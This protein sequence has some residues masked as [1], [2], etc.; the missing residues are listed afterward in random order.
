METAVCRKGRILLH[1][2]C[3]PCSAPILEWLLQNGLTPTLFFYNPNIFPE[4]EYLRRKEECIRYAGKLGVEFIDGDYDHRRWLESVAG[5]EE[6]P[7]RGDRCATCFGLRM[8]ATAREAAA[9]G[10]AVFTTTLTG[11]RWKSY[12]QIVDAGLRAVSLVKGIEFWDRDWKK[13]GLTERRNALLRENG[14]YNQQYCGC[15]FSI[16]TR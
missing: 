8:D 7:E 9:S 15:E 6:C 2:C 5:Q 4:R 3:A 13:R 12:G 16:R 14:F 1:S 11:S 10:F